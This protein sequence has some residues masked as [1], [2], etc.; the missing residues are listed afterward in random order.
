MLHKIRNAMGK[1]N[2]QELNGTVEVDE[3]YEGGS[4]KN[5]HYDKKLAVKEKEHQNKKLLQGFV[6]RGGNAVIN[7][8]PDRSDSTLAAG[9]LRYVEPGSV[10]YSDDNPSY[11]KLPPLYNQS[12]VVHSKGN[13]VCKDNK[14]IYTNTIESVWAV[15]NRTIETHI[16]VS[17]KHL[18]NYANELIFLSLIHISEPTRPY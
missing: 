11:Q 17:E 1:E 7:V 16:H 5:M 13:Y 2:H 14:D 15:F 10:L 3:Y 9:V 8:I 4:L 6:E 12:I 18:Q